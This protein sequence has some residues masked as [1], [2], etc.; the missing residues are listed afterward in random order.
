[1]EHN[2]LGRLPNSVVE[3]QQRRRA[4]TQAQLDQAGQSRGRLSGT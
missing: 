2:P 3:L 1:M 4:A